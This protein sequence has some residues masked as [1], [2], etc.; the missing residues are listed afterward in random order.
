MDFTTSMDEIVRKQTMGFALLFFTMPFYFFILGSNRVLWIG[1]IVVFIGILLFTFLKKTVKYSID[2]N[3]IFI[4]RRIGNVEINIKD[5]GRVDKIHH[6]L[7]KKETKGGAFGYVG[8]FDAEIGRTHWF[9][10][11]RDQL[12]LITK[13]DGT[14]IMLSPDKP[15]EFIKQVDAIIS[16]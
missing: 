13:K 15:Y 3:S 1:C 5:I 12:V 4:R 11:R 10:T 6:D 7:L 14:K 9:T 8:Q 2:K 16:C